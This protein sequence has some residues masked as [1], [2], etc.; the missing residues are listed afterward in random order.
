MEGTCCNFYQ[1]EW[2]NTTSWAFGVLIQMILEA[3]EVADGVRPEGELHV[4]V[5]GLGV[6]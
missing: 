6:E 4:H 5:A 1:G 2:S 3:F